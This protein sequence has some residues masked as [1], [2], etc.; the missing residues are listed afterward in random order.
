MPEFVFSASDPASFSSVTI[1]GVSVPTMAAGEYGARVR[2]P[3]PDPTRNGRHSLILS[4]GALVTRQIPMAALREVFGLGINAVWA[5]RTGAPDASDFV[6]VQVSLDGGDTFLAWT[7]AE[8]EVQAV[9][10][11]FN[12]VADFCDNCATLTFANPRHLGFRVRVE[13][14]ENQTPTLRSISAFVEWIYDPLVDLDEV[15]LHRIQAIRLPFTVQTRAA[16]AAM[17]RIAIEA[18]LQADLALPVRVF[19]L[20]ADPLKNTDLFDSVDGS[21]VV[22]TDEQAAGSRFLVEMF[23]ACPT[24]ITRQDEFLRKTVVPSI[25]AR[26]GKEMAAR[27]GN[28]GVLRDFKRGDVSRRVRERQHTR[29]VRLPLSIQVVTAEP[30]AARMAIEAVRDALSA[31]ELRSLASGTRILLVEDEPGE[32]PTNLVEGIEET[33]WRGHIFLPFPSRQYTEHEGV[34]EVTVEIGSRENPWEQRKV[35]SS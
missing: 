24:F 27:G 22:L 11:V 35:L 2:R 28:T 6:T 4:A 31:V 34:R 12:S 33:W 18:A 26:V 13:T 14:S 8:W 7:G 19:N 29:I 25:V 20:V 5:E 23:R 3:G 30:R 16:A 17:S 1:A 10:E 9:D 32:Q 21:D 15:L